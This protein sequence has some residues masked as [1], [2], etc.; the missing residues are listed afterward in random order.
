MDSGGVEI[1]VLS[2]ESGTVTTEATTDVD[3]GMI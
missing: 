2:S 1:V 3:G